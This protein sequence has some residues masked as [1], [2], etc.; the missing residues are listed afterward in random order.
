LKKSDAERS[1]SISKETKKEKADK[2]DKSLK[3]TEED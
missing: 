1:E 2:E 3:R